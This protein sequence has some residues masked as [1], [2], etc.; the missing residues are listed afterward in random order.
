MG[1]GDGGRVDAEKLCR[2]ACRHPPLRAAMVAHYTATLMRR[3]REGFTKVLVTFPASLYTI[4]LS[5][6]LTARAS[7]YHRWSCHYGRRRAAMRSLF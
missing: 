3:K 2:E 7:T 4:Y 5:P 1:T 6:H